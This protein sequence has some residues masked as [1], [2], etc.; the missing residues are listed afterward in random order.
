MTTKARRI[1]DALGILV[2]L[3][4]PKA[5]Q[6]DRSAVSLL[7]LLDLRPRMSWNLATSPLLGITPIMS[8]ARD[9]YDRSDA[10]NTRETYRRQTMHQLVDAGL[11]LY[12]PD[13][14]QRPVNSPRTVYRISPRC[15]SS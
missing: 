15:W 10:P 13:D 2:A 9:H 3:G 6:N 11:A 12:N 5:Q 4:M 1:A 14:P 8:W 7:A